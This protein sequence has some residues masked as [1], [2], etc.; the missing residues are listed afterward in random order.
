[1]FRC[2]S[3]CLEIFAGS[4]VATPA[5]GPLWEPSVRA[6]NDVGRSHRKVHVGLLRS[7]GSTGMYVNHVKYQRRT[8]L[9]LFRT[10]PLSAGTAHH[11][12]NKST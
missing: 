7:T 10:P 2:S 4:V 5:V 12:D 6:K 11:D 9:V 1:M 3:H 8:Y